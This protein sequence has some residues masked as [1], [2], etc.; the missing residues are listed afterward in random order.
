LA[1]GSLGQAMSISF[2]AGVFVKV[3]SRQRQ[4]AVGSLGQAMSISFPA[5]VF[6]KVGSREFESSHEC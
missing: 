4:L 3:G 5:G 2:P 6:V 1:V